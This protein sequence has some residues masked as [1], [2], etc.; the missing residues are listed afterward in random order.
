MTRNLSAHVSDMETDAPPARRTLGWWAARVGL[1]LATLLLVLVAT[2]L[3]LYRFGTM[4]TPTPAIQAAYA[5][6][7]ASG[8]VAP[9]AAPGGLHVPIPGC[10]C[11]SPDP[12]LQMQHRY[13][14]IDECSRCHG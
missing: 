4:A 11:H 2:G 9:V 13:R 6:L 10:T 1:T 12:V 7:V 14:T 8:R 3:V 5:G